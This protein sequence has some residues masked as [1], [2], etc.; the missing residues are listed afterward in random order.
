[1]GGGGGRREGGEVQLPQ[2][3]YR[4][5]SKHYKAAASSFTFSVRELCL[6]S[7]CRRPLSSEALIGVL[8]VAFS[9]FK[10]CCFLTKIAADM[11]S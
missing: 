2:W 7:S 11:V 9:S 10:T 8:A 5:G 6:H 1:M 3:G 4:A